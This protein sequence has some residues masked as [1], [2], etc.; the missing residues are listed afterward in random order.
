MKFTE[1]EDGLLYAEQGA[2]MRYRLLFIFFGLAMLVMPYTVLLHVNG[3]ESLGTLLVASLFVVLPT[4]LGL[5]FIRV[6]LAMPQ[7]VHFDASRRQI[8]RR[9]RRLFGPP[10][11]ETLPFHRV[12][13]LEVVRR[14]AMEDPD[15]IELVMNLDGRR[16]LK[17]GV[18]DTAQQAE[19]WQQRLQ[20]LVF[21]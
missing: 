21:V 8:K 3:T 15:V 18:Y 9:Q 12:Q 4:W 20:A 16:P 17:L 6:A 10:Q 1:T 19:Q 11:V 2:P 14:K 5:F 7:E 13:G